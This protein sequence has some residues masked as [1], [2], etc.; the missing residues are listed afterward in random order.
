MKFE[1][2]INKVICGDC[3]EVMKDIPD[4]SINHIITD[5]PYNVNKEYENKTNEEY[6][7]WLDKVC[8]ELNRI[9][10]NNGNFIF[11]IGTK[12][13]PKKISIVSNHFKYEWVIVQYKPTFRHFGKTGFTKTDLIMWFSKGSGK[14]FDKHPDIIIDKSENMRI[15][16]PT[17]KGNIISEK[18]IEMFTQEND[19]VLDCF[20]GSGSIIV[21]CAK[22]NR[23]FIGIEINPEYCKIAEERLRKVPKRLDMF[24]EV[25][26]NAR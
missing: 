15:N 23:R 3:L 26:V 12:N 6:L 13:L 2:M 11:Y 4:N 9:L 17:F 20:V 19:I 8:I 14:I 10:S 24:K 25:D 1:D 18:L 7:L 16:H 22:L 5:F 21:A